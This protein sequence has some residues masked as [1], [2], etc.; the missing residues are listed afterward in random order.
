[1][2]RQKA[3]L[4][5]GFIPNEPGATLVDFMDRS[6]DP[7]QFSQSLLTNLINCSGVEIEA[8][9]INL[10][11][12]ITPKIEG[13]VIANLDDAAIFGSFHKGV[14]GKLKLSDAQLKYVR[15]TLH[16]MRDLVFGWTP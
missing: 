8:K 2:S 5:D 14:E 16:I 11:I 6:L 9:E 4:D 3:T 1:M 13:S 12:L 10:G 15:A 7:F